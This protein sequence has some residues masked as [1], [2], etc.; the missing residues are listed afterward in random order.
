MNN[1]RLRVA[2]DNSLAKRNPTGTGVY[3]T[4]LIRELTDLYCSWLD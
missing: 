4:Q 2:W 3:A 1:R